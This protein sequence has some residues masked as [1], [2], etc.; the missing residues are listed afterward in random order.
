[1]LVILPAYLALGFCAGFIWKQR[2]GLFRFK[3]DEFTFALAA[4]LLTGLFG[5]LAIKFLSVTPQIANGDTAELIPFA[6][7]VLGFVSALWYLASDS[8]RDKLMFIAAAGL[9]VVVSAL[10]YDYRL[11]GSLTKVD[12]G[13]VSLEFSD[14]SNSSSPLPIPNFT[15]SGSGSQADPYPGANRLIF[16]IGS[17]SQLGAIVFRDESY[18]RVLSGLAPDPDPDKM[19]ASMRQFA[20]YACTQI[21][22]LA[23]K[24]MQLQL[25]HHGKSSTLSLNPDLVPSLRRAYLRA[26]NGKDPHVY[27]TELFAVDR[28]ALRSLFQEMNDET[29]AELDAIRPRTSV[30]DDARENPAPG[31][32]PCARVGKPTAYFQTASDLDAAENQSYLA[33]LAQAAALAEYAGG[34]RENAFSLLSQ[35]IEMQRRQLN[36]SLVLSPLQTTRQS[37]RSSEDQDECG[38]ASRLRYFRRLVALVRLELTLDNMYAYAENPAINPARLGLLKDLV[39]DF[40]ESLR[41]VDPNEELRHSFGLSGKSKERGCPETLMEARDAAK[42]IAQWIFGEVSAEN[43]A[44]YRAVENKAIVD[45]LPDWQPVLDGYARDVENLD[46]GCMSQLGFELPEAQ[47]YSLLDSVAAYWEAKGVRFGAS[48]GDGAHLREIESDEQITVAALCKAK[49]TYAE[50]LIAYDKYLTT[51]PDAPNSR[52]TSATRGELKRYQKMEFKLRLQAG[53]DRVT[54]ILARLPAGEVNHACSG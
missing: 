21:A 25:F 11:L 48:A 34:N 2:F 46:T 49:R 40:R 3:L 33:Y 24:L 23:D 42:L 37:C 45:A 28:N 38:A 30:A 41:F 35:E 47:R 7:F 9:L 22:P 54:G 31:S 1:M 15:T 8:G 51:L 44:I 32:D 52:P 4:W 10:E 12:A 13:S 36:S 16:V 14:H 6:G 27:R 18:A 50:A 5:V 39:S 19:V 17:L 43:N 20:A 29:D 26:R 53:W